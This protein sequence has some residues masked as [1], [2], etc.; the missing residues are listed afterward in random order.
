MILSLAVVAG[1]TD[2]I[3]QKLY[4]FV[5]HVHVSVFD[6][7]GNNSYTQPPIYF[8]TLMMAK[9]AKLPHVVQA[10][11]FA[12][13]P[14]IIQYK[15]SM[16][17]VRMKGVDAHYSFNKAISLTG[18]PIQYTDSGYAKEVILSRT[19]ADKLRVNIGD[20][21]QLEF[22]ESSG[23]PRIRRVTVASIYHSGMLEVDRYYALCDIKL[24][25]RINN[26]TAD[27]IN[28]YQI[29]VDQEAY[30]NTISDRIHYDIIQ[31]P[32]A[33]YT[34]E[35]NYQSVFEWLHLQ[36]INSIILIVI[37]TVVAIINMGAVLM[38]LM[39]DR[40]TMIGLLKALGM[41]YKQV[42]KLFLA[43]AGIIASTGIV[44][45]N[46][47]GLGICFI[48]LKFGIITL[49]EETYYMKYAPIKLIVWQIVLVDMVTLLVCI[50]CMSIPV[51]YIRKIQPAKVLQFK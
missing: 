27:S 19:T 16:E 22:F 47:I 42:A 43:M 45:G 51:L 44:L 32:L 7:M 20:T 5:G 18:K 21:V 6:P 41:P 25:Q 35:E 31:P 48:Q 15:G 11:P 13:R 34:T 3:K 49:P 50:L 36:H 23:T 2:A 9:M 29:D 12:E 33:S 30:A 38:I 17:G 24:L 8:D 14:V 40:A 4:S 10:A 1:F 28:G 26:W 46:I 39:V 37:M